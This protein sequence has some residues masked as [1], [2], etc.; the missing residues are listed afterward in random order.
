MSQ[1][2]ENPP[3][4]TTLP[5]SITA[6]LGALRRRIRRYVLAEGT[7]GV[8]VWLGLVFWVTLGFDW[9]FEP[10][11]ALRIAVQVIV[12]A[13]T[14]TVVYRRLLRR[15]FAQLPER[16]MALLLE[17][18][19]GTFHDGLITSVELSHLPDHAESFSPEMLA[20]TRDRAAA[21]AGE[22]DVASVFRPGPW[23]ISV[24]AAVLLSGSVGG[25]AYGSP[26]TFDMWWK[27]SVLLDEDLWPRSTTLVV[28]GFEEGFEIVAEGASLQIRVEARDEEETTT[29]VWIDYRTADGSTGRHNMVRRGKADGAVQ[30]FTHVFHNVKSDIAF[31]VAGGDA[32]LRDLQLRVVPN[33]T[34]ESLVLDC[35]Y[36]AYTGRTAGEVQAR[37]LMPLP[38]GTDLVVRGM[39]NKPLVQVEAFDLRS[40]TPDV[41][42]ATLTEGHG[43]SGER[44]FELKLGRLV[45]D[46]SLVFHLLDHHGIRSPEPLRLELTAR[47]DDPPLVSVR[48]EGV[49]TSVTANAR[50]PLVGEINDDYGVARTWIEYAVDTSEPV[51]RSF[52]EPRQL[53]SAETLTGSDGGEDGKDAVKLFEPTLPVE[54]ALEMRE[55]EVIAGQTVTMT[56][57]A[58]DSYDAGPNVGTGEPM[59]LNIVTPEQ[60]L[61]ILDARELNLRRRFQVA[62]KEVV[63][64]RSSLAT[65]M[66]TY[67]P[68]S[69]PTPTDEAPDADNPDAPDAD[70]PDAPDPV[71]LSEE[72]Q[73]TWRKLRI[74]RGLQTSRRGADETLGIALGFL[75]LR[76]EV[77]NNRIDSER[78]KTLMKEL[79]ADPLQDI[80]ENMFPVLDG[81]LEALAEN[82]DDPKT[83]GPHLDASLRQAD[84][85]LVKM[86]AILDNMIQLESFNE[87]I[88]G[89]RLLI[90]SQKNM[91][92]QTREEQK[93][94]LLKRIGIEE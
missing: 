9:F 69:A 45:E 41:P 2:T 90:D 86:T 25:L 74:Q 71:E 81:H 6:A 54:T 4:E 34:I 18:R 53:R 37:S 58:E 16:S 11:V 1:A 48:R 62:I 14:L 30:T 51:E 79:V 66:A 35:R 29:R 36:P 46:R 59:L 76:Q 20:A 73:K 21:T 7:A 26:E 49:G 93:R 10:P 22:V 64:A 47:P 61:E 85:I 15:F 77:I 80:A 38:W 84:A 63:D 12:V 40:D 52:V 44:E 88:A 70:N 3:T 91:K 87:V 17:R 24:L 60:L 92:Q 72:E 83:A 67:D 50:V 28:D 55:L 43:L 57:K 19:F 94:A 5:P 78:H 13:A 8:V 82:Q 27:R 89:L 65:V 33:P 56:I 32:R 31:D 68:D 75:A 42:L 23:A 39:A